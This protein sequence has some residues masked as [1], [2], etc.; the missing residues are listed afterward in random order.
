M[1]SMKKCLPDLVIGFALL[2]ILISLSLQTSAIPKD[3]KGYPLILMGLSYVMVIAFIIKNLIQFKSSRT[4]ESRLAEQL[5]TIFPYTVLILAYLFLLDKI[6]YILDTF[7]FCMVS[8]LYLRLKN[9]LLMV[10]LSLVLTLLLYF[11][12]TRFLSVILPRGSILSLSL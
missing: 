8:L 2:I 3:S 1:K 4:V 10:V 12:F 5:K 11:I 6:G 9:K 7:L